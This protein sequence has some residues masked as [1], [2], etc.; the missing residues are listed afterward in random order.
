[1]VSDSFRRSDTASCFY[2]SVKSVVKKFRLLSPAPQ[3]FA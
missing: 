3:F 1:L 2:Q